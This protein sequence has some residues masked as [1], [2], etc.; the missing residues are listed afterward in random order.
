MENQQENVNGAFLKIVYS[1]KKI[2]K[3]A[4]NANMGLELYLKTENQ[5][6]NAQ[7]ALM[8]AKSAQ[9]IIHFAHH[10]LQVTY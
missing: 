6:A 1:A 3:Y 9:K 4:K 7:I 10:A 2:Q 8:A 5:Q